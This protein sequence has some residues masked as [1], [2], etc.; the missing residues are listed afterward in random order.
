MAVA[1]PIRFLL[2]AAFCTILF[3]IY[4]F[5]GSKKPV[6]AEPPSDDPGREFRVDK[7]FVDPNLEGMASF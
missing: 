5:S 2:L 7:N 4:T 1:R 3:L 6:L